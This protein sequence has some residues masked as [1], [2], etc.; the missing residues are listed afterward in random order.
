MLLDL[1]ENEVWESNDLEEFSADSCEILPPS[2]PVFTATVESV[3]ATS[4]LRWLL[5]YLLSLQAK[6]CI[7][8]SGIDML[9]HFLSIFS[10]LGRFSP[11]VAIM[12]ES[13]PKSKY[14][15]QRQMGIDVCFTKFVLCP[16]CFKIHMF[17]D[18]W[19]KVGSCQVINHCSFV[20]YP[21]HPYLSR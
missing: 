8:D 20:R 4:L 16:K 17:K 14:L 3:R 18:T 12:A 19:Q 11:I 13:F 15:A 9:L 2:L 5:V 21:N 6:Y 1:S 7:P 10:I